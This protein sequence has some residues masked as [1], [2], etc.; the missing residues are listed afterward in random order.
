MYSKMTGKNGHSSDAMG[1]ASFSRRSDEGASVFL[2][3]C[4]GDIFRKHYRNTVSNPKTLDYL[5]QNGAS[6]IAV[7]ALDKTGR[8]KF[9]VWGFG[10]GKN[11]IGLYD[12][13]T[14][15]DFVVFL[16]KDGEKRCLYAC[17]TVVCKEVNDRLSK[18]IWISDGEHASFRNMFYMIECYE[19]LH[20]DIA[21]NDLDYK[22]NYIFRPSICFDAS[23]KQNSF[24]RNKVNDTLM[25]GFGRKIC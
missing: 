21:P 1:G 10:N 24:L 9:G 5:E 3:L 4:L 23:K 17:G 18:E 20:I 11:N 2:I 13:V 6:E 25:N 19:G 7:K 16:G 8:K 14:K 22:Y 12:K 15:G